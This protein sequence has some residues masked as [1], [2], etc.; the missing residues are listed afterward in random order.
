[1]S[2]RC[3]S[4]W[5]VFAMG[6]LSLGLLASPASAQVTPGVRVGL[7]VDPDQFYIGG[8]IETA[9]LIDRLHFRPNVEAGFGDDHTLVALNFEFVY[10]FPSRQMWQLY[11]GAGPGL[12]ISSADKRS[13]TEG[14]FNILIGA[15]QS[16][17]LF[18][19]IKIGAAG[20]PGLKF[21]VGY[22]FH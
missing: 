21:G 10:R 3:V 6:M 9:P 22:A 2:R 14:G 19:E 5:I 18:F 15:E 17:G 4:V 16:R 13:D 7:S 8:H 11:V 12:N 1:M 20:S